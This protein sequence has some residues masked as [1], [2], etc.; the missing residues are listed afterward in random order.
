[1][2]YNRHF[3]LYAAYEFL[4]QHGLEKESA[5]IRNSSDKFMS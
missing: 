3:S 2:E 1:M 4:S 5:D